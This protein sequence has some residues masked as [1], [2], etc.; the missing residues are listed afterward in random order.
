MNNSE[1]LDLWRRY[2]KTELSFWKIRTM[3]LRLTIYMSDILI[4]RMII[5]I[6]HGSMSTF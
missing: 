3:Y 4:Q 6:K 2:I 5:G 1:V